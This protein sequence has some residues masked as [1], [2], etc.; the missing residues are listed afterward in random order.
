[1]E[2][3]M[4]KNVLQGIHFHNHFKMTICAHKN[5][6]SQISQTTLLTH[7]VALAMLS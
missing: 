1:M 7:S 2:K 6:I 4:S 3:N 5:S